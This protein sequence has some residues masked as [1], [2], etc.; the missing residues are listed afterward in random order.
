[1]S[2][3]TALFPDAPRGLG[4]MM[5]GGQ[6]A[7]LGGLGAGDKAARQPDDFYP[8]P[9]DVTHALLLHQRDALAAKPLVWEPCGGDGAI[10]DVLRDHGF[11]VFATDKTPRRADIMAADLFTAQ[12]SPSLRSATAPTIITNPP[13]AQAAEVAAH[14]LD[15]HRPAYLALLLKATWWHAAARTDLWRRHRPSAVLALT[16]RPDFL[17]GGSPTMECAWVVWGGP[18][19]ATR[20][21]YDRLPRPAVDAAGRLTNPM[22]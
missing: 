15:H 16:W 18:Q 13:F 12:P 9:A 21:D 10:V 1:M 17:G 22:I 14:L 19:Q 3:G 8:T 11:P 20:T 6:R 7:A 4:R 2:D 5:A